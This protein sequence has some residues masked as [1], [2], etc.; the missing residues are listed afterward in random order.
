MSTYTAAEYEQAIE[1]AIKAKDIP[2]VGVL[3]TQLALV[4]PDRAQ[5]VFDTLKLGVE[6]AR[7]AGVSTTSGEHTGS[8]I[9]EGGR[10]G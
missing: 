10:D 3:L 7:R 5:V 6:M 1:L 2:S 4:D 9:T 8:T